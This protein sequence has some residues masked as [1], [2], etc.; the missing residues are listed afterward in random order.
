MTQ[1]PANAQSDESKYRAQPLWE[2]QAV[3][4][5][6]PHHKTTQS[7]A[8]PPYKLTCQCGFLHGDR[9]DISNF[10]GY[11]CIN[12]NLKALI[13]RLRS[14]PVHSAPT[15]DLAS[16]T[17]RRFERSGANMATHTLSDFDG[18]RATHWARL[19]NP[20]RPSTSRASIIVRPV[21]GGISPTR[22]TRSALPERG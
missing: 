18:S 4:K 3:T 11:G 22:V 15:T 19:N 12:G 6:Q 7:R 16:G 13:S 17:Q 10:T 2:N 8:I 21:A 14:Q 1:N 20:F 5:Q 9:Y